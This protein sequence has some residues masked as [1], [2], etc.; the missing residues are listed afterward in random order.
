L[1]HFSLLPFPPIE[2]IVGLGLAMSSHCCLLRQI[3]QAKLPIHSLSWR[4]ICCG[5]VEL[6]GEDKSVWIWKESK[7]TIGPPSCSATPGAMTRAS[8]RWSLSMPM[9]RA[10]V[11]NLAHSASLQSLD[12]IAP[13]KPGIKH[14]DCATCK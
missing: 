12:K 14:L 5:S 13:S 11:T 6:V 9:I 8:V 10:A 7:G 2:I 4:P 1:V 3:I